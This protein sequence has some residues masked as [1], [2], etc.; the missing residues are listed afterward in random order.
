MGTLSS[1]SELWGIDY[2]PATN[3]FAACGCSYLPNLFIGMPVGAWSVPLIAVYDASSMELRW[4]SG[5][6]LPGSIN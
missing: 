5:L 1:S 6:N 2:S 4:S 3:I